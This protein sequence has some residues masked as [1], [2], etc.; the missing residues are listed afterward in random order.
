M[1]ANERRLPWE[2]ELLGL[3]KVNTDELRQLPVRLMLLAVV[4]V[5]EA[6]EVRGLS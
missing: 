1:S 4:G 3:S 6:V 5:S 2:C